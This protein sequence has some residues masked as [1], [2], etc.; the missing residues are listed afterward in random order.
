MRCTPATILAL[1]LAT[2]S[3]T[4]APGAGT[5]APPPPSAAAK[6][7]AVPAPAASPEPATA[8]EP[9]AIPKDWLWITDTRLKVELAM[10]SLPRSASSVPGADGQV[11]QRA[12]VSEREGKTYNLTAISNA[13]AGTLDELVA[14]LKRDG[15]LVRNDPWHDDGRRLSVRMAGQVVQIA[16]VLREGTFY[17]LEVQGEPPPA[18]TERFMASFSVRA[19]PRAEPLHHDAGLQVQTPA[20][21]GV[22]VDNSEFPPLEHHR[23][24]LDGLQFGVQVTNLVLVSDHER[25][26]DGSVTA[27][28]DS[29]GGQLVEIDPRPFQGRPS[30]RVE[31]R[32]RDGTYATIR[33]VHLGSKLVQ[34]TVYAPSGREP[35]WADAYV[36][37][38]KFDP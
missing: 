7:G 4:D 9:G 34:V 38:L 16:A 17:I 24:V 31:M 5:P 1:T 28:R 11:Q 22:W 8:G 12:L 2:A 10:P 30:R 20:R 35:T 14:G 15:E 27:M 18:D 19:K 29:F 32:A 21:M 36:D 33:L 3:C 23:G 13:P 26:L 37:S 6:E 25:S